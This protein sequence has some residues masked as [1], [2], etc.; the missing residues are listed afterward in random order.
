[1]LPKELIDVRKVK[2]KIYPKFADEKDI[3]LAEK[4]LQIFKSNI[5]KKY[6][7]IQKTLKKIETADNFKKV[8]GFAK[9][10]ERFCVEKSC[11]LN[12]DLDPLKVRFFLFERGF[13]VSKEERS[14]VIEYA[15]K[16]FNTNPEE[17]ENAMYADREEEMIVT[18]VSSITPIELIKNYNLS[19]LQTSLFDTISVIFEFEGNYSRIFRAIKFYGLMY[20]IISYGK[21]ASVELIGPA[22]LIKMTKKYGTSIAKVIP[23]VIKAK[24]W[25]IIAKILDKDRIYTLEIDDSLKSLLPKA[26]FDEKFDSSLEEE[27]FRKLRNLGY[28]VNREMAIIKSGNRAFIPDF[29]VWKK[30]W[31]NKV[32]VEIAGFWTVEYIKRK[33][34][35]IRESKVPMVVIAREE[36]GD[37]KAKNVGFENV[38]FVIF[39]NKLDYG[40]I[41]KAINKLGKTEE[42]FKEETI[43]EVNLEELREKCKHVKN[44]E[45]LENLLKKYGLKLSDE[46]L[47]ALNI[48]VRWKGL[49]SE[50]IFK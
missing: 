23:E 22:T 50:L 24:K 12:T 46:I 31:K 1:M 17:I 21:K 47:K 15:A 26:K 44:L 29:V 2:G 49:K 4:V 41:I 9:I 27:F 38:E 6:G 33:I 3:E 10:L 30:G 11:S 16:Y 5:G 37:V 19:L 39:S 25:K 13:V 28:N 40:K 43:L 42:N 36:F 34:E 14:K 35:K 20:E 48:E 8:R 7:T 45:D 32:Y 18:N